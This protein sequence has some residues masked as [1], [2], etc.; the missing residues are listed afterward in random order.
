[1]KKL[2]FLL[3]LLF[4]VSIFSQPA[5]RGKTT[6]INLFGL[7][8][9][10]SA[11]D[12]KAEITYANGEKEIGYIDGFIQNKA[13][14]VNIQNPFSIGSYSDALN[15]SDKSF[16]FRK[17]LKDRS[18][19]IKS[20]D[21]SEVKI[22]DEDIT[23]RHYKLM[24]LA[25]VNSDGT[26]KDLKKKAW[27]PYYS[28]GT[29]NIFSFDVYEERVGSTGNGTGIF[30]KAATL[31]YLNDPK[32]NVA[33]NVKDYAISDIFK[34]KKLFNKWTGGLV[35]IFKAC[36]EFIKSNTDAKGIWNFDSEY[37]QTDELEKA[38][39]KEIKAD[40]S[41]KKDVRNIMLNNLDTDIQVLPYVRMIEAYSKTCL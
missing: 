32:N 18:E 37:F 41:I 34:P 21:V 8:V 22:L 20:E 12:T 15:L 10:F 17:T 31:I 29:T 5:I 33:I 3:C 19:L 35:E 25:T 4:T 40:K 13:L 9:D 36:P 1:M 14:S 2:V 7:K 23:I 24:N 26:I 11:K 16:S 28:Q 38:K 39:I 6:G 30:E 27:L